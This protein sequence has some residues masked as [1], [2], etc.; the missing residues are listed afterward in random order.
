MTSTE[1]TQ[2]PRL[3]P[4]T[5]DF[6]DK[7]NLF[8]TLS[9]NSMVAEHCHEF[10]SGFRLNGAL[11]SRHRE[12]CILR[13]AFRLG[14][15]YEFAL[16]AQSA[17]DIGMTEDEVRRTCAPSTF[18][19][20]ESDAVVIETADD[21]YESGDVSDALWSR[22]SAVLS[23]S[24]IIEL[25]ALCGLYRTLAIVIRSIRVDLDSPAEYWPSE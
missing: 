4:L 19:W 6:P 10:A 8:A 22:V 25:L 13:T 9:Y 14:S 18:G 11:T 5:E 7:P 23:P 17:L 3:R 20:S 16:H 1:E 12:L 15:K 2:I 24:Q 21:V